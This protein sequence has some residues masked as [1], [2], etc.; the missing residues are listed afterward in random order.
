M[1]GG[2]LQYGQ[3]V[4]AAFAVAGNREDA[5]AHAFEEGEAF[6]LDDRRLVVANTTGKSRAYEFL[7]SI[8]T[9]PTSA[10]LPALEM[11]FRQDAQLIYFLTD[12]S[13]FLPSNEQVVQRVEQLVNERSGPVTINTI[14]FADAE[15]D[16]ND[17]EFRTLKQIADLTGGQFKIV[18]ERDF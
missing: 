9:G 17:P 15:Y 3:E 4:D 5:T 10:P 1:L 14:F 11:A 13:L 16:E 18:T 12:G 8:F 7:A 6:A 2:D